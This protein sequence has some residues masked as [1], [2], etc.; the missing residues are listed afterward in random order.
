VLSVGHYI[1]ETYVKPLLPLLIYLLFAVNVCDAAPAAPGIFNLLQPDG[2]KFKVENRG[3]EWCHWSKTA[4]GY[5]IIQDRESGWWYYA[6]PDD[7]KDAK[8]SEFPVGTVDPDSLQ[9]PKG[10]HIKCGKRPTGY[11][12]PRR[13]LPK[14][15]DERQ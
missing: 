14:E 5:G 4:D 15:E 3:D 8:Q 13:L 2:T 9:I 12:P 6:I 11:L 7:E 10:L 1:G